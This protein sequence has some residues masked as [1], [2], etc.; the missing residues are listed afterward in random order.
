MEM[1][2]LR[3]PRVRH[4]RSITDNTKET[5]LPMRKLLIPAMFVRQ[6]QATKYEVQK[7]ERGDENLDMLKVQ[8][9]EKEFQ[10]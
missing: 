5:S 8:S 4:L 1:Q 10:N 3:F 7:H 6:T 9:I 2:N